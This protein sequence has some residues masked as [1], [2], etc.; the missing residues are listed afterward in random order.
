MSVPRSSFAGCTLTA[1]DDHPHVRLAHH[2][3][4]LALYLVSIEFNLSDT[5]PFPPLGLNS[6]KAKTEV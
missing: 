6:F 4:P 2:V 5:E 1:H 3:I